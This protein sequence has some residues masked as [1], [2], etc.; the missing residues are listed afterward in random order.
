V[1]S[2]KGYSEQ[3]DELHFEGDRWLKNP[4]LSASQ[5]GDNFL[6][7]RPLTKDKDGVWRVVKDIRL[8]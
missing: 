3:Y 4:N 5:R 7:V 8:E 1:I 2:G 6:S